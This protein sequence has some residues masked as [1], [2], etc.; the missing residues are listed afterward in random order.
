MKASEIFA[1]L[2]EHMPI[3]LKEDWDNSGFLLGDT[4]KEV[5]R[6]LVTLDVTADA[7]REA[8]EGKFDLIVSHHPLIFSPVKS[9]TDKDP[10][11]RIL[12][13]LIK[14]DVAVISMHT[15]YDSARTGVGDVLARTLGLKNTR[16]FGASRTDTY[17][18]LCVFVPR[19]DK[20]R[21]SDVLFAHG[22]GVLGD[23]GECS[24]S[25]DGTGTFLP[26][27]GAHPYIGTVGKREEAAEAKLE[28]IIPKI[29]A[30][31]II[32]AMREAHPYEEPAFDLYDIEYP[33]E[34]FGYGKV[35]DIDEMDFLDFARLVKERLSCD[36]VRYV[37]SCDKVRRVAVGGGSCAFLIPE[38][39]AEGADV[40]VTG[41]AKYH[42]MLDAKESGMSVI[43]AGHFQTEDIAMEPMA[44]L[45][46]S[47]G[48]LYV[49]KSET[50]RACEQYL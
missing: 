2:C 41:D 1:K 26:M 19:E 8:V 3:R 13:M 20:A 47:F 23:Y 48:S 45:I 5:S 28:V 34:E 22:A 31:E 14:N 39:Q 24:F 21:L 33:K 11:S 29:R 7:A 40:F 50:H 38:A 25:T 9:I 17:M 30:G 46:R 37:R 15:N 49:K 16:V 44:E 43:A 35:G 6:V 42:E 27:D 36:A 32:S 12:M 10:L 18:K 4:K